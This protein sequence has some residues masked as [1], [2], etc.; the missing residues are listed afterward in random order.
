MIELILDNNNNNIYV[1][2]R[3]LFARRTNPYSFSHSHNLQIYIE[4]A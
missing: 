4:F 1:S 2:S 3:I